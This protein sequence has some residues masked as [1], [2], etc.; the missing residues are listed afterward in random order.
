MV[1]HSYKIK[2]IISSVFISV[3]MYV[4]YACILITIKIDSER[5][6]ERERDLVRYEHIKNRRHFNM[7]IIR[8][9]KI[10]L[11]PDRKPN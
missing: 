6:R 3:S 5:E 9:D 4:E 11:C 2:V 1:N 7:P 8:A 10:C